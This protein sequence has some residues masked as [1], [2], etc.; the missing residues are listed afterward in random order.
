MAEIIYFG[1]NL[2]LVLQI[3]DKL[4]IRMWKF[5]YYKVWIQNLQTSW[6][7]YYLYGIIN[8][9]NQ[10]LF[11]FYR[12]FY[13]VIKTIIIIIIIITIIIIIIIIKTIKTIKTIIIIIIIIVNIIMIF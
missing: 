5:I 1:K 7:I 4:R 10:R 2:F 9:K 11:L 12:I 6:I 13:S 3:D 8:N